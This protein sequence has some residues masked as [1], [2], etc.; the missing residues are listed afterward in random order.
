MILTTCAACAAPLA[1]DHKKR[2]SRCK[3]RYC[4]EACQ[5]QHWAQGH[6]GLCRRIKRAGGAEKNYAGKKYQETVAEAVEA[7]AD[8]RDQTRV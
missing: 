6:E 2:C 1:N 5:R 3:T 4:D 8:H 7:C